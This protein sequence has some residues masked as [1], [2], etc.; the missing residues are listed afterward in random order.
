MEKRK[1]YEEKFEAQLREWGAEI[2]LFNARADKTKAGARIE[3]YQMIEA[4]QGKED[5]ARAK[6]QEL[7]TAGDDAWEDLKTG[8]ENICTEVRTAFQN[9]SSRFK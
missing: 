7:M 9:A 2:A 6:L 3:Y 8:A 4:L 1:A 5:E